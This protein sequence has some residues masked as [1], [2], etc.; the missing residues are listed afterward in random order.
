[1]HFSF[2]LIC[3]NPHCCETTSNNFK[4]ELGELAVSYGIRLHVDLCLGGFVLPF[5]RKLCYPIP[6]FDFTVQG[7]TSISANVHKYATYS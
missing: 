6:P 1:M 7:M 5:A 2:S 4:Q 3:S